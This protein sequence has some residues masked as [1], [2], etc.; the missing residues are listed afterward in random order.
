[1]D[2][3]GIS[4]EEFAVGIDLQVGEKFAGWEG[5]FTPAH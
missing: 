5:W 2:L 3:I 4:N 1:M